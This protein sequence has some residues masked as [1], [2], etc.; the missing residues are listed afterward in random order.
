MTQEEAALILSVC[1][2]NAQLTSA[3]GSTNVRGINVSID[4][5]P[6]PLPRRA[7][8]S[9]SCSLA[10][11][12]SSGLGCMAGVE[13]ARR[14]MKRL[15]QQMLY[16]DITP[17]MFQPHL[18]VSLWSLGSGCGPSCIAGGI[19]S[20]ARILL[21]NIPQQDRTKTKSSPLENCTRTVDSGQPVLLEDDHAVRAC[22]ATFALEP[23]GRCASK[24]CAKGGTFRMRSKSFN[25]ELKQ[26]WPALM[27]AVLS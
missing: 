27:L 18:Q 25:S 16:S 12:L 13:L 23:I 2:C 26:A 11:P 21:K 22:T 5:P 7:C 10:A 1:I 17:I 6:E 14:D 3:E 8:K 20:A 9:C 4:T 24:Q 19:V 15:K